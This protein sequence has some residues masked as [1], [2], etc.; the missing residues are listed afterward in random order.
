MPMPRS[1]VH[2]SSSCALPLSPPVCA[3][4]LHVLWR[5]A[6]S[7]VSSQADA[8]PCIVFV[9][10]NLPSVFRFDVTTYSVQKT[11]SDQA[12]SNKRK[13][14]NGGHDGVSSSVTV[15]RGNLRASGAQG[16]DANEVCVVTTL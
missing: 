4:L 9:F 14:Q 8:Q 10:L 15:T 11:L 7:L 12:V 13:R 3:V 16:S 6:F 1:F 5:G 2:S